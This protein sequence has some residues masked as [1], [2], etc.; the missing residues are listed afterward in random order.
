VS[1]DNQEGHLGLDLSGDAQP[2]VSPA[3]PGL[4]AAADSPNGDSKPDRDRA[5]IEHAA[6]EVGVG[7]RTGSRL[8]RL[9]V[10]SDS[11]AIIIAW[12][13]GILVATE[14]F[15]RNVDELDLTLTILV[16][17][18]AWVLFAYLGGLYHETDFRIDSSFVDEIGRI[19]VVSTAWCWLFTL[20]RSLLASSPTELLG[21]AIMWPTM[22]V[23]LLVGRSLVK[24]FSSA[25][26]WYVRPV[27]VVGDP[28]GLQAVTERIERH[29]EWGLEV[30]ARIRLSGG[31]VLLTRPQRGDNVNGSEEPVLAGDQDLPDQLLVNLL[32]EIGVERAILA[33]GSRDL[34]SRTRLTSGLIDRGIAVDLV[35]GGPESVYSNAVFHEVEGL[36]VVS[37]Q[38]TSPGP[39]AQFLKR[40]TDISL[41]ALG[42]LVLSPV[43]LWAALRIKLDSEGTVFYHQVRCG[44]NN[45]EFELVK[46]RTMVQ[47]AHDLRP[48]LREQTLE[49]GNDDVL[50]KLK[51]DPRVTEFGKTLRRLSIDEMP[52]LWNV[53]KGDMS[54]VGPRPLVYEEA[55][56]ATEMFAARTKMK[57]GV[58]GPWQALGRSSI[59]FEDMIRLDY[60]YVV[61]W[62]ISLDTMLL[63]RTVAAVIRRDGAH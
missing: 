47:G 60:A 62:S 41:S 17:L 61:G 10:L 23:L 49:S 4:G 59:P 39:V 27:A 19:L 12:A 26:S 54:M 34:A 7:V 22:I 44:K 42:L 20:V 53:F 29:P 11:V 28:E 13:I 5:A 50:F 56:Q 48:E 3:R 43:F 63:L 24:R 31:R 16:L 25:R 36:P 1:A 46:F 40:A 51:D 6:E 8:R 33:G 14:P 30:E 58:A 9:L 52:Q 35:S 32:D 55:M 37:M 2:V 45:E 18:P 15:G 38:P 21:T 57:P